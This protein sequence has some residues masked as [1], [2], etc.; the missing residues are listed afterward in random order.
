MS[1]KHKQ[2]I[3]TS[4]RERERAIANTGDLFRD[5]STLALRPRLHY[6]GFPLKSIPPDHSVPQ[7]LQG[8]FTLELL[9]LSS[10][11]HTASLQARRGRTSNT[12]FPL[13]SETMRT[14]TFASS[15]QR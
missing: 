12:E 8:E 15:K 6:E 2:D 1:N 3:K 5:S 10:P 7:H 14:H 9:G 13:E 11:V 4:K